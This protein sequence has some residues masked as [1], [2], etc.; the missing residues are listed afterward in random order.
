MGNQQ[1]NQ[2][3]I[4]YESKEFKH[5][6]AGYNM[7]EGC[8]HMQN[9]YQLKGNACNAFQ[10]NIKDKHVDI[11]MEK[12]KKVMESVIMHYFKVTTQVDNFTAD[13]L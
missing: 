13:Y 1:N 8:K 11:N 3:H 9:T 7:I 6:H 12:T 5:K 4:G 2:G 10:V